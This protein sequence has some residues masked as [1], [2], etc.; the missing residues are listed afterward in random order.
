MGGGSRH[1][2]QYANV[3]L[4]PVIHKQVVSVANALKFAPLNAKGYKLP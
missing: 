1:T 2:C 3:Y 4:R